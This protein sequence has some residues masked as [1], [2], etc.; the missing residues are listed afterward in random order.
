MKNWFLSLS[1]LIALVGVVSEVCIAA[2]KIRIS[3][4]NFNMSFLPSG[5]EKT[6]GAARRG[7]KN[8]QSTDQGEPLHPS[9]PRGHD[10]NTG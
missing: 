1:L 7:Q 8:H 5:L 2:D 4:S 9:E 6:Q 3:V 10:S